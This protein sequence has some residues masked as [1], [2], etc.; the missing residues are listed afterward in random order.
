M[1]FCYFF[2]ITS[3]LILFGC[4]NEDLDEVEEPSPD[5]QANELTAL[6]PYLF[7]LTSS[8]EDLINMTLDKYCWE[9]DENEC[10][11]IATEPEELLEGISLYLEAD[12]EATITL[13]TGSMSHT[14]TIDFDF[15]P[16]ELTLIQTTAS[17][18]EEQEIELDDMQF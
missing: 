2:I 15:F 16:D 11:L 17:T 12:A 8:S 14:R 7:G 13:S 10:D 6:S 18:G 3:F 1:K 4:G 9:T 5:D